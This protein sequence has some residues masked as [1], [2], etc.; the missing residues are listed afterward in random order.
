MGY[1]VDSKI[2][3]IDGDNVANPNACCANS[4]CRGAWSIGR[5]IA[6]KPELGW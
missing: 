4:D 2:G 6:G 5:T 1:A 3:T